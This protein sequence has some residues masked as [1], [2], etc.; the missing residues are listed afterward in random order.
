MSKQDQFGWTL[1]GISPYA[2]STQFTEQMAKERSDV[3]KTG[4]ADFNT[5]ASGS[6]A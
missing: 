4:I 3:E 2:S 6:K 5:T 1:Y